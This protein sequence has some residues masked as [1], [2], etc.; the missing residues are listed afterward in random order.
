M[1]VCAARRVWFFTRFGLKYG[2]NFDH[3]GLKKGYGLCTL[4]LILNW[5]C[6]LEQATSSSLGELVTR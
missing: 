4:V 5:V 6:F 1:K 3:F 2:T